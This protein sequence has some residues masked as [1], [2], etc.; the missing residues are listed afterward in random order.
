MVTPREHELLSCIVTIKPRRSNRRH[1]G[2]RAR[3]SAQ[4]RDRWAVEQTDRRIYPIAVEEG[5]HN[6]LSVTLRS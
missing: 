3:A 6:I 1:T 2:K 5:L 4:K